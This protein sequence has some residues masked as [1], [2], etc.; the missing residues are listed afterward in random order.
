MGEVGEFFLRCFDAF[1]FDGIEMV[2]PD[3]RF[4]GELTL[5]IG[6]REVRLIEVGPARV[7][8]RRGFDAASL[9]V[10]LDLLGGG[11]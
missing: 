10:V 3:Q 6:S 5:T 1:S 8:V 2:F 11:R 4:S 9:C 7:G